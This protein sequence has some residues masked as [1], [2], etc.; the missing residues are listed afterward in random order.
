MSDVKCEI[1]EIIFLV[2][3]EEVTKTMEEVTVFADSYECD[4][5]GS[6]GSVTIDFF[7][8]DKYVKVKI[9]EW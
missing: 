1:K 9:E 5:C 3:G 8:I 7:H 2:D 6:H 4:M